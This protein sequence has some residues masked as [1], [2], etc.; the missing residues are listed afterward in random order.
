MARTHAAWS[1]DP[2]RPVSAGLPPHPRQLAALGAATA[3]RIARHAGLEG[4]VFVGDC[5]CALAA[6]TP[7]D[8]RPDADAPDPLIQS[9]LRE[10]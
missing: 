4:P 1:S 3:A 8:T 7:I 6:T 10:Q 2:Q 9:N 5:C